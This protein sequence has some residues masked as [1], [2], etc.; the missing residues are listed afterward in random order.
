MK[1]QY[2]I[3][4]RFFRR[5]IMMPIAIVL[6]SIVVTFCGVMWIINISRCPNC[7]KT[8]GGPANRYLHRV[9]SCSNCGD[10][11][12]V[13]PSIPGQHSHKTPCKHCQGWFFDC[14]PDAA[15]VPK[16]EAS[17]HGNGICNIEETT[18]QNVVGSTSD[19]F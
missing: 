7:Q 17:Q 3:F 18:R 13:C 8:S 15:G 5:D 2:N 11:C 19:G 4:T 9:L 10:I 14:P 16:T 6:I 1:K 12:W